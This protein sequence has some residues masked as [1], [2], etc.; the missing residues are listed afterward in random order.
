[1]AFKKIEL[2][3]E[4]MK[5][6]GGRQWKKFEA[7]GDSALGFLVKTEKAT[8]N[9]K[10]GPK[11]ITKWIFY[12][13]LAGRPAPEEFEVTPPTDL[14][15]RL[16]KAEREQGLR[17][18]LG[19]LVK[20]TFTQTRDIEGRTDK[21][22]I[23]TVEVDTEFKPQNPLPASVT[24]AKSKPAEVMKFEKPAPDDDIPF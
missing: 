13:K 12:G 22:K 20:M 5:S 15:Q 11:E 4:E 18:G 21:K 14:E 7:I 2:T 3:E 24:W 23:F 10:E 6:G 1:M 17:A 16:E 19:H 9:Y 8:A